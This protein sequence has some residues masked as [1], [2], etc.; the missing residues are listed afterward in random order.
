LDLRPR[1]QPLYRNQFLLN[2][3]LGYT[4][5]PRVDAYWEPVLKDSCLNLSVYAHHRSYLG[6]YAATLMHS[7][8]DGQEPTLQSVELS[9]GAFESLTRAGVKGRYDM[10][11]SYLSWGASYEGIHNGNGGKRQIKYLY[12]HLLVFMDII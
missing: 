4:L 11:R 6:Q 9:K 2:A 7:N 12:L 10:K 8:T 5:H 1:K 3:S